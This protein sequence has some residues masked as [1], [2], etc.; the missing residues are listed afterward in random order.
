MKTYKAHTTIEKWLKMHFESKEDIM[1][2]LNVSRPTATRIG[3]DMRFFI[4]YLLIISEAT[5]KSV[6]DICSEVII[7]HYIENPTE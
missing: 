4:K 5:G 7:T 6:N 3:R 2:A 1:T